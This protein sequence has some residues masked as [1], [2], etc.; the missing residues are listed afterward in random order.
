MQ[1]KFKKE[2]DQEIEVKLPFF[3]QH[4]AYGD[5]FKV[6]AVL[7]EKTVI[8][9]FDS[10]DRTSIAIDIPERYKSE[11]KEAYFE[12]NEISEEHFLR[13]YNKALGKLSLTPQLSEI[14]QEIENELTNK[15]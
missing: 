11:I 10:D 15:K 6:F 12:F 3:R 9:L 2:I 7:D 14:D 5:N 4:V 13:V 1:I 8:S